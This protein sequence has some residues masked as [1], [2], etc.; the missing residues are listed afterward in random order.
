MENSH[1]QNYEGIGEKGSLSITM[2]LWM[3][4]FILIRE[5]IAVRRPSA[6]PPAFMHAFDCITSTFRGDRVE[7]RYPVKK[8]KNAD[9]PFTGWGVID[10]G[11]VWCH[12]FDMDTW[13]PDWPR[14]SAFC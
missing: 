9:H 2:Q 3:M 8:E 14:Q 11:D 6:E 10:T 4:P 5:I 7:L 1:W 12:K 13:R